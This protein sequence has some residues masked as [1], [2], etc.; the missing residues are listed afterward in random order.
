LGTSAVIALGA[1]NFERSIGTGPDQ[2]QFN[3]SGLNGFAAFDRLL[4]RRGIEVVEA[5][6]PALLDEPG[7]LVLTPPAEA[8]GADLAKIVKKRRMIG[9]TMVIAPKWQAFP[10]GAQQAKGKRGWVTISGTMPPRWDGFYDDIGVTMGK[11]AGREGRHWLAARGLAG[12]LPAPEAVESGSGPKLVPLVTTSDWRILAAHYQ[13]EGYYPEL[14]EL[15][16]R[17]GE[18]GG[19]NDD[20]YPVVMVFEPDLLDN[21]GM[22]RR[23]NA[24]LAAMLVDAALARGPRKVT[25]D[26]TLNGLGRSANLLTL[27]FTPPYLAATLCLLLAALAAGW[28]AFLRLGPAR[29]QGRAIAFG[30]RALVS[31]AAGLIRRTRRLHLVTGPYAERTRER[32]ASALGLPRQPTPEATEQAVDRALARRSAGSEA[33][34]QLAQRLRAARHPAAI[35][36]AA[37]ALHALER[38]ILR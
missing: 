8:K 31:A 34:S 28:R 2:I 16:P 19:D 6:N 1:N 37:Q 33:F 13:D 22:A 36:R 24:E 9:P 38:T 17:V 25:F 10:V 4:Q 21:Y 30:K 11:V 18:A 35:L 20:L 27:A 5:R 15:G 32:L 26:L 14:A 7:L 23:A 12:V 3:G 29:A